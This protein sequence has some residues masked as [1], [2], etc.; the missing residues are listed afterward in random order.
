[1]AGDD[2]AARALGC[3]DLLELVLRATVANGPPRTRFALRLV[4][5][6]WR[7][8]VAR[9]GFACALRAE[10]PDRAALWGRFPCCSRALNFEAGWMCCAEPRSRPW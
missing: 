6:E 5:K 9:C 3:G 10:N 2:S 4:C 8:A 1:M 7:D